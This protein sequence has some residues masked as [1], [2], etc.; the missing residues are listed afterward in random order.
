MAITIRII[1]ND[2]GP[3]DGATPLPA[4]LD[5]FRT[6]D[7]A[8]GMIR[9]NLPVGLSFGRF[10]PGQIVA[11]QS[12]S[13]IVSHLSVISAGGAHADGSVMRIR[14][15]ALPG[16][17]FGP[18]R[19]VLNFGP[20]G[21]Q[22]ADGVIPEGIFPPLPV[23]HQLLFDTQADG[24][25][26]GPHVI[27][28]TLVPATLERAMTQRQA[29]V[30]GGGG[31]G[32]GTQLSTFVYR[33][34]GIPSGNVY[35]SWA[36]MVA[37]MALVEGPKWVEV[38]DSIVSPA[39]IP[40]G[41]FNMRRATIRGREGPQQTVLRGSVD[42]VLTNCFRI[43]QNLQLQH[44]DPDDPMIV[45]APTEFFDLSDGAS[46][47]S[48]TAQP[49]VQLQAAGAAVVRMQQ[50]QLQ[51]LGFGPAVGTVGGA[52][53]TLVLSVYEGSVVDDDTLQNDVG[54]A[55]NVRLL[56]AGADVSR[57]HAAALGALTFGNIPVTGTEQPT[58]DNLFD[59]GLTT[60]RW[61]STVSRVCI[62]TALLGAGAPAVA[63]GANSVGEIAG[64]AN[65]IDAT[66]TASL[67]LGT[68]A[69][70][71]VSGSSV[72]G[73]AQADVAG[74]LSQLLASGAGAEA[75]GYARAQTGDNARIQGTGYGSSARGFAHAISYDATI[76]ASGQGAMASGYAQPYGGAGYGAATVQATERGSHA[77][78]AASYR[79]E[80]TASGW[81]AIAMGVGT[82]G[83]FVNNSPGRLIASGIGSFVAGLA[84]GGDIEATYGGSVALGR[85]RF[86]LAGYQGRIRS[87]AQGALAGGSALSGEIVGGS[88]AGYGQSAFAWGFAETSVAGG[89]IPA[90]RAGQFGSV[91]MGQARGP[92]ALV[93]AYNTGSLAFGT[94]FSQSA[95]SYAEIRTMGDQ[96]GCVAMG[97]A[98]AN[99]GYTARVSA[100]ENGAF[101]MGRATAAVASAYLTASGEGSV[102]LGSAVG[103]SIVSS[104][105]GSL[106]AG[107]VLQGRTLTASGDGAAAIGTARAAIGG[108]DVLASGEGS[109]AQGSAY[110]GPITAS[111]RNAVQLG[112]GVNA[113]ADSLRVGVAGIHF[114]GTAGVFGGGYADGQFWIDNGNVY[115]YSGGAVQ[116]LTNV[117]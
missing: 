81:G 40:T 12:G 39:I 16:G 62:A 91:A 35:T 85:A 1:V 80:V 102:A 94:A 68:P 2:P 49:V 99:N 45:L 34:G 43:E 64:V 89:N 29:G 107:S 66:A 104:G 36:A 33:P 115:C 23:G 55:I 71:E 4:A 74:S 14:P 105:N 87:L 83:A 58:E 26:P 37:D 116:N 56:D 52:G 48:L 88:V 67:D 73:V 79:G 15:P 13:F 53:R 65:A 90:L 69:Q 21:D 112:P 5:Q 7:A 97:L 50:G 109:M 108:A 113:E 77:F 93:E 76:L 60:N 27:Q 98:D 84:E 82:G 103:G 101:A 106:A 117:P 51:D 10:D 31:G 63:F 41:T 95:T 3:L 19:T 9:I 18:D 20:P 46:L 24:P 38:D 57:S 32:G 111:A 92:N 72:R 47:A 44:N 61:R 25:A 75:Q 6:E 100:A 70:P 54:S 96:T 30:E 22:L 8:L 17:A 28:L 114:K 59:A 110:T 86:A 78:G 42:T 11:G